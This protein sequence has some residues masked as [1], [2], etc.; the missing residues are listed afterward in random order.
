[1]GACGCL[2]LFSLGSIALALATASLVGNEWVRIYYPSV[3]YQKGLW[4]DCVDNVC[5][6]LGDN[7]PKLYQIVRSTVV[8]AILLTFIG[9]V[10]SLVR[11]RVHKF[12]GYCISCFFLF[13][14]M[15]SIVFV[16]Q[17]FF[18]T[19]SFGNSCS[20]EAGYGKNNVFFIEAI[21]LVLT[22]RLV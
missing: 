13:A 11:I 22:L 3:T 21:Y 2:I 5:I 7:V 18:L 6:S 16:V 1:M 4:S 14:G 19:L 9:T 10:L 17:F 12:N 8:L 15:Y 20:R